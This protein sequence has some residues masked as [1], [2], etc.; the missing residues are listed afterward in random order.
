MKIL[1]ILTSKLSIFII[2]VVMVVAGQLLDCKLLFYPGALIVL[3]IVGFMFLFAFILNPICSIN[4]KIILKG[5]RRPIAN[6]PFCIPRYVDT[7]E[8][9][10]KTVMFNKDIFTNETHINKI[11]GFTVGG[12]LE[13]SVHKNSF[14][15]G[16][17][18]VDGKIEI[19]S[20][21]YIDGKRE[22]K[23]LA[24]VL[25]NIHYELRLHRD[26]SE[27]KFTVFQG[28]R[29]IATNN[30]D[31]TNKYN[32]GY[33]CGLYYGGKPKAPHTLKIKIW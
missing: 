30:Y 15:Y 12:L 11:F 5:F 32:Y 10:V 31:F 28:G 23:V 19:L 26:S 4:S 6:I 3:V 20:Y 1:S 7:T 29:L 33:K 25:P 17:R 2:G 14:R 9:L 16:W 22:F 18:I 13:N 8:Y 24:K 21:V 27:V